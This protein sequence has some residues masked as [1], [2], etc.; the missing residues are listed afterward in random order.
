MKIGVMGAGAIGCY[1][2]GRLAAA[3]VDVTLVGRAS[4]GEEI[5]KHGL[6]LTDYRGFD[7]VVRPA[8][9]TEVA[10]LAKHDV[11]LVT[12]KGGDTASVAEAL[13]PVLLDGTRVISFQ[14]GVRNPDILRAALPGRRVLAGMVP[15][16]VLRREGGHFHQGTSGTLALERA[17]GADVVEALRLAGLPTEAYD[18]MRGVLWGK[19]LVNL[20]NSVNALAD[21]PIKEMLAQRDYRRVMAA[22]IREGLDAVEKAGI[23]PKLD[24]ALPPRLVPAV[25][26]MPNAIFSLIARPLLT[27]DPQARS[28][29]WDDLARGRKTEIDALNGEI[30]RLAAEVG[31]KAPVNAAIVALVREAEG[32]GSPGL[33]A[34]DLRA[35]L[36]V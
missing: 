1:V 12:V 4:L 29:M 20:N 28:S 31:T 5:A 25:L 6:R 32:R 24:V 26:T 30:V 21:I 23:R 15:F 22:C 27:V 33:S 19:L 13:A 3:G 36:R 16:N 10:R 7:R 14:N 9:T 35:R 11:V 2:G 8:F 17:D 34:A 18:D